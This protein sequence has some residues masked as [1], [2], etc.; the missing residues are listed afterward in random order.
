[1]I[2]CISSPTKL[3]WTTV[4][5]K[6]DAIQI[7]FDNKMACKRMERNSVASGHLNFP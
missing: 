5:V 1:M 7:R 6:F 3:D 4:E 2:V